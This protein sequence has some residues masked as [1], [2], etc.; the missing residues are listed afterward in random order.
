MVTLATSAEQSVQTSGCLLDPVTVG[1]YLLKNRFVL[2]PLTRS[3]A[4]AGDVPTSTHAV[5]YAQRAHA[6]LQITEGSPISQQGTGFP[7]TP[8]IYTPEQ[9]EGWRLVTDEVHRRNSR[10]FLQLWHVGRQSHTSLQKDGALPVAPSAIAVDS[11]IF[12]ADGLQDFE[13]PRA[14]E[15]A[16]IIAIVK[17]F[18]VGARNALKAGFDGVEIHGASGY[19]IDQFLC[20]GSN[21]RAD[22]YGGSIENRIRFLKE[23]VAEVVSV[24]GADRVGVRLTPSS[25]YGDMFSSDKF[26]VY[27][28]AVKELDK[29]DLA[30]L[31]LVEPNVSGSE[32]VEAAD[33]AIPTSYFRSIYSGKI[34]VAGGLSF[35]SAER[36][37]RD[38]VADL[39]GFGKAFMANP[40]LPIRYTNGARIR[41]PER[42][43]YYGGDETG[44]TDYP[45]CLDEEY[46]H[47][48]K[49]Q[50]D[51]GKLS[52]EEVLESLN[53]GNPLDQID[54]GAYYTRLVL[55]RDLS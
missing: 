25:V 49:S 1:P 2:P 26:K 40:D 39:V 32:T 9:V 6:G 16:E 55:N 43:H 30:Y 46:L 35:E 3:R 12:T 5:Y 34:I 4:G 51:A 42:A 28:A 13:T 21:T 47:R 27:T 48:V 15:T 54:S 29:Y 14:L 52:L 17:E 22:Q 31:H 37:V 19:L 45:S 10:I 8:G 44:Y 33:D 53:A 7:W 23:V 50:I 18:G 38:E 24:W 11:K 41:E 20:E 36:A